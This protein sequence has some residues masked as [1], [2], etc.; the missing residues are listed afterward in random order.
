VEGNYPSDLP[1][2]GDGSEENG[3]ANNAAGDNGGEN[4]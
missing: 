3:E 2:P 1:Q 4:G